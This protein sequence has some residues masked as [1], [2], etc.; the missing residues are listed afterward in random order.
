MNMENNIDNIFKKSFE[1]SELPVDNRVWLEIEKNLPQKH[2]YLSKSKIIHLAIAIS[3][4]VALTNLIMYQNAE[5][6]S[7]IS[8]VNNEIYRYNNEPQTSKVNKISFYNKEEIIDANK[9]NKT[10]TNE[11]IIE[12]NTETHNHSDTLVNVLKNQKIINDTPIEHNVATQKTRVSNYIPISWYKKQ[13]K[14]YAQFTI[15][16]LKQKGALVFRLKTNKRKIDLMKSKGM[17]V[18]AA[19]E[20][21][22]I[23]IEN[24]K[25]VHAFRTNFTF[26]PV[27][28]IYSEDSDLLKSGNTK[29][30]FLDENLEKSKNI[31]FN[32][33][34]Y[35]LGEFGM[36]KDENGQ[37]QGVLKRALVL[38]DMEFDQ[39]HDPFPYALKAASVN[40]VEKQVL[41]LNKKLQS[42]YELTQQ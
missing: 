26:C 29:G 22:K 21:N 33:P 14:V 27:Y 5:T 12:N 35:V 41:R 31:E 11:P 20:E 13:E 30:I 18:E 10:I 25:I 1:Q 17:F 2:E 7:A 42:F 8:N 39:M 19:N 16:N 23:R 34:F 37:L 3:F 9:S 40:N 6:Y 36:I 4:S 28:F 38:K 24:Q 32:K 15:N